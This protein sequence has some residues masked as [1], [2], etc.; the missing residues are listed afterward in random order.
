MAFFEVQH[1]GQTVTKIRK[2]NYFEITQYS[3]LDSD[4]M[5]ADNKFWVNGKK[6]SFVNFVDSAKKVG[7][8]YIAK[9]RE[10]FAYLPIP[11]GVTGLQK[12]FIRVRRERLAHREDLENCNCLKCYGGI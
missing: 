8:S 1:K 2:D 3:H 10:K 6:V 12:K 7:Q 4:V 11:A 9:D 5:D